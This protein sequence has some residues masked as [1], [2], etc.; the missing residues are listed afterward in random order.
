M[1]SQDLKNHKIPDT[2]GVYFFLGSKKE[3]LYIGKAT[4]LKDRVK[5]Y[6]SSDL[7]ETR[8]P[9][10]LDM[11]FKSKDIKWQTTDSVLEALILEAN[12]IKKY[13][14]KYNTKEKD[15]KSFNYVCIT[16]DSPRL[17]GAGFPRILVIRGRE[18]IDGK[19][20]DL[21]NLKRSDLKNSIY[22][23]VYGSYTSGTSLREA[24]K[25]IRRIFPF[26]DKNSNSKN[27]YEFYRQLGLTPD[28][29]SSQIKI[30]YKKTIRNIK[31][32]FEGKKIQILKN[33]EKE[34]KSLAKLQK[35][36]K[37]GE[38]KRKI[39]ALKHIQDI[40]LLKEENL[41][42]E[43][44]N[45]FRIEGYDIA[46]MG[47]N[48]MVGVMTVVLNGEVDKNEYR[49]FKIRTIKGPDDTGSLKEIILRRLGHFEWTL[50][51][52]IVVDGGIAQK[53]A[54]ERVLKERGFDID[55]VSVV[56][57]ERHRPKD[58]LGLNQSTKGGLI[59]RTSRSEVLDKKSLVFKREREI[60]LVNSESHRFAISYH[61][62]L[63]RK[64]LF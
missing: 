22:Q 19:R 55:V 6:F 43:T 35:F 54:V 37:A 47:G 48:N 36:E 30:E 42:E 34:M 57:D 21:G 49:K 13:K 29:K 53:N 32:F 5:S 40:S 26:I 61:R 56:K 63:R 9:T 10:I 24:L 4:S 31:L 38:L 62:N 8:G 44:E 50:P 20:S 45:N 1:I 14:P 25:I 17:G 27:N 51:N 46:H 41:K 12:L 33:L 7:I 3:I 11:V 18:L 23:S 2:P 39:F 52:L 16:K 59:G 15:D 60:L 64:S 28:M 58:I